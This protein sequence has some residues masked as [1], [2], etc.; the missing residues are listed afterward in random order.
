[1]R[2]KLLISLLLVLAVLMPFG[3]S[4]YRRMIYR[5]Y[6]TVIGFANMADGIGRQSVEIIDVMKDHVS[7]GFHPS[8]PSKMQDLPLAVE[9]IM[10][11]RKTQLGKIVL[12]EDIFSS[13]S[14]VFFTKRFDLKKKDELHLA[15]SM[16]E[17]SQIPK[18]WVHN[19]N[20]YFDAV[21]VPDP[22]LIDT[23]KDSGVKL[24]IFVVPLG[25]NLRPFL[26]APLKT[27]AH[28]PFIF[29]NFSTCISRK[30]HKEL[31]HAFHAAFGDNPNIHLWINS[32]SIEEQLFAEL[33]QDIISL[34][35]HNILLTHHCYDHAHYLENFQNID[36]YVSLSQAEGFSIQPREA[37]ALGIPCIVSD[38]TA[39]S[40]ICNSGLVYSV[41][42]PKQELAYYELFEDVFGHRYNVDF[43]ACVQALRTMYEHY[44]TYLSQAPLL[45]AWAAQY[46]YESLHSLY[47]TLLK[48]KHIVL[49]D[50]DML[51][52]ETL[53]TSSLN[54]YNKYQAIR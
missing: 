42:C 31:I 52:G 8:R 24:P 39:Q 14:N 18:L 23:Y 30:N 34:G 29:A 11:K 9:K 13:F 15:Y 28:S 49:G 26:Q 50:E 1:M 44:D 51:H 53:T 10:N 20:R 46:D 35:V 19:L 37:M 7:V 45:R 6:L 2:K 12:Y 47:T 43:D 33:Q 16:F 22:F 4:Y 48:P 3:A 17:S 25:L 36:C 41:P 27:M 21:V 54:L 32:R 40:T 38:N 5:P